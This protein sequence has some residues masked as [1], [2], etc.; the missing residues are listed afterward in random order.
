MLKN[1]RAEKPPVLHRRL[2]EDWA[3]KAEDTRRRVRSS[4]KRT[5]EA[6]P[7]MARCQTQ[8]ATAQTA[9]GAPTDVTNHTHLVDDALSAK[10]MCAW[11]KNPSA[12]ATNAAKTWMLRGS[13]SA[14]DMN[15][16]DGRSRVQ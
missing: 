1:R 10:L 11:S 13:I 16:C 12:G 7:L 15:G 8:T 2:C 6:I 9:L 14:D 3:W 5:A 4:E